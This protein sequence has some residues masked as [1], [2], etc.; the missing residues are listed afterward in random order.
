MIN[1]HGAKLIVKLACLTSL[2]AEMPSWTCI[3]YLKRWVESMCVTLIGIVLFLSNKDV[4]SATD[5][6]LKLWSTL[7]MKS[8]HGLYLQTLQVLK[9][10]F[11]KCTMY[12]IIHLISL[13]LPTNFII[14]ISCYSFLLNSLLNWKKVK[15]LLNNLQ[16]W[17]TI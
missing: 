6:L 13:V 1:A 10:V 2:G 5:V 3:Q 8:Y 11:W 7:L 4:M 12:I 16:S 14:Y 17:W 15:I 9:R